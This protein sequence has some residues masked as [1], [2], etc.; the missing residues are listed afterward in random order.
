MASPVHSEIKQA[1]ESAAGLYHRLVLVVGHSGTGKTRVLRNIAGELGV[2]VTNVNLTLAGGLLELTG[3]QRVLQL[4]EIFDQMVGQCPSPVVLDNLEILCGRDLQT[5]PLK[6][7]QNVSRN[8]TVI[9]AWN[10]ALTGSRLEYAEIGHP[11]Y[12]SYDAADTLIV[13]MNATAD[14]ETA[15]N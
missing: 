5:N 14:A 3:Y 2:P 12:G 13:D 4:P 9:A 11:E 6:L 15:S 1:L 7:L 10:G 8:S